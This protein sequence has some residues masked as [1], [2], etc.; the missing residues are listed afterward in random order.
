MY[1]SVILILHKLVFWFFAR[2]FEDL[3]NFYIIINASV[4]KLFSLLETQLFAKIKNSFVGFPSKFRICEIVK[5]DFSKISPKKYIFFELPWQQ[6]HTFQLRFFCK[7][8]LGMSRTY[9]VTIHLFKIFIIRN[10]CKLR[11]SCFDL[12]L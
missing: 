7:C 6:E 12:T 11:K 9:C 8:I 2:H 5:I 3:F 1:C 4:E 10:M